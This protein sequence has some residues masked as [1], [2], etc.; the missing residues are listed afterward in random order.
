MTQH[1][2]H[3]AQYYK[4]AGFDFIAAYVAIFG[5]LPRVVKAA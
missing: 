2:N 4:A 3:Y 1:A 5:R